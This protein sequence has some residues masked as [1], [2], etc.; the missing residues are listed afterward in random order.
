MLIDWN[1]E[2]FQDLAYGSY[3]EY[4]KKLEKKD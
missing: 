2:M 3:L 1:I 4:K